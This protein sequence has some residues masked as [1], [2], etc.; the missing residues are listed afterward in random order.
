MARPAD[1]CEPPPISSADQKLRRGEFAKT[2]AA[3]NACDGPAEK[4]MVLIE[5]NVMVGIRSAFPPRPTDRPSW[6]NCCPEPFPLAFE[7][8]E[9]RHEKTIPVCSG[10][11]TPLLGL[12]WLPAGLRPLRRTTRRRP[13]HPR[14]PRGQMP[15]SKSRLLT[16][17][18]GERRQRDEEREPQRR[19]PRPA[20]TPL[21]LRAPI[22]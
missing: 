7:A 19:T 20:K 12:R 13:K 21:P 3:S 17:H 14:T 1:P 15:T 5:E 18:A 11:G 4:P 22:P 8:K 10:H 2:A 9:R 16:T 6:D